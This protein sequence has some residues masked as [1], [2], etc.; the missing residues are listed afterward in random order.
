[1][2]LDGFADPLGFALIMEVVNHVNEISEVGLGEG[3]MTWE[4]EGL[5]D[6]KTDA[7][8]F[9]E[10]VNGVALLAEIDLDERG[11]ATLQ[12][13][14]THCLHYLY[15]YNEDLPRVQQV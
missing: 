3:Q 7:T 8:V 2:R 5:P 9:M 6:A 15:V 13:D 14:R 12:I 4:T 11:G 10:A 1:V